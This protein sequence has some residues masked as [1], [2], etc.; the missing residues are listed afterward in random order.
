MKSTNCIQNS[1]F[2]FRFTPA[3]VWRKLSSTDYVGVKVQIQGHANNCEKVQH[4]M[5]RAQV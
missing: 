1:T 5:E 3:Y 4:F 2:A